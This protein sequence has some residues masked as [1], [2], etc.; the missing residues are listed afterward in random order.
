MRQKLTSEHTARPKTQA[1]RSA[2]AWRIDSYHER[3]LVLELRPRTKNIMLS[4][5][6]LRRRSTHVMFLSLH[7]PRR[8]RAR[9]TQRR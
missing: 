6:G 3:A 8:A 7:A 2:R 5:I 1:E 9:W 4:R